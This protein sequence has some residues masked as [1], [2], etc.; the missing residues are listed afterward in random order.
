MTASG[1]VTNFGPAPLA[2]RNDTAPA[3]E[4]SATTSACWVCGRAALRLI[5]KGNLP[6]TLDAAHF[7]ITDS[8]YGST[9][10]VYECGGCGFRQ[11]SALH[12]VL[13]YYEQMADEEYEATR[14]ARS[15]Q[16]RML[17]RRVA[18]HRPTGRLLDI[19]AGSG[20]LVEQALA[21][22]YRAEGVEPSWPLYEQGLAY[23]LPLHHGILPTPAVRGPYDIATMVDVI[24]HVSDPVGML[25][26]ARELLRADGVAVV[27]TP[28]VQSL[29]ARLLG[30]RWW[31][32]RIAHIGYFSR[33]NLELALRRAGLELIDV[34]RPAWYFPAGYL[35]ERALKF[36]P[37][38]LRFHPPAFLQKLT[39]RLNLRDSLMVIARK[40]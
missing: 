4:D 14:D 18:R 40:A 26:Q 6:A 24:E 1:P 3:A 39:V 2:H 32:Y 22:G 15:L 29:V 23:G 31:H 28:D 37:R 30:W 16:A 34:S 9:A 38:K 20:I 21:A 27:V 11:S 13:R 12:D 25:N 7:R 19:G 35:A 5:H 33:S 17:L 8:A 10:D 36:V